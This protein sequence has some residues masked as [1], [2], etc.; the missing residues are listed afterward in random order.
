MLCWRVAFLDEAVGNLLVGLVPNPELGL[1]ALHADAPRDVR[2]RRVL[3]ES[4]N[5]IPMGQWSEPITFGRMNASL[6][7]LLKRSLT[8]T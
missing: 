5:S 4:Q 3:L 6:S 1:V 8:R 7:L 2:D